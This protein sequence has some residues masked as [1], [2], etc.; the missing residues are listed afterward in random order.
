MCITITYSVRKT[1]HNRIPEH[2]W[3]TTVYMEEIK[4]KHGIFTV[5]E[6]T[7]PWF[8]H[9]LKKHQT[10]LDDID[11]ALTWVTPSSVV[12]DVGAHVGLFTIPIAKHVAHIHAIEP[13]T[14]TF[15]LLEQNIERNGI[16]NATLHNVIIADAHKTFSESTDAPGAETQYHESA[17][18]KQGVPLHTIVDQVDFIKIDVEGMELSVLRGAQ[19]LINKH[20][21]IILFEV[22]KKALDDHHV[23]R[24][25]LNKFFTHNQYQLYRIENGSLHELFS[26]QQSIFMNVLAIPRSTQVTATNKYV[27]ALRQLIRRIR[28]RLHM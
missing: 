1:N 13:N 19:S 7:D 14:K 27:Y 26:L 15:A 18:G 25:E 11:C 10:Q 16:T 28:T 2:T 20:K 22:N 4:T 5:N 9:S 3:Y 23:D 12:V 6:A 17:T 21:P 24:S 8:A